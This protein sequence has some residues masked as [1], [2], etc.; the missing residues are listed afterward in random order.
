[1]PGGGRQE[2]VCSV[3]LSPTAWHEYQITKGSSIMKQEIMVRQSQRAIQYALDFLFP[4]HC[5]ACQKS[6]D[7]LCPSCL[8]AIRP[9]A[10]PLCPQCGKAIPTYSIYGSCQNCATHPLHMSG[11]RTVSIYQEPL[12]TCIHALKYE[13]N[14]RLAKPL[15]LLLAKAYQAYGIRADVIVPVPLHSERQRQRGYN[16]TSLLAEVCA[17]QVG[18]P[19]NNHMLVRH[20]ATSAQVGLAAQERQQNVAGAFLCTPSFATGRLSGRTILIIDDV[21]TTGATIE[22]CALPLFAAGAHAVWGLVLARP[23]A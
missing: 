8:A 22:A 16:Q 10:P 4:P 23:H 7:I 2:K 3:L 5:A 1:M 15:G 18:V 19:L 9:L 6:G 11:L 21:C 20:R 14:T 17:R 13:G 12:R